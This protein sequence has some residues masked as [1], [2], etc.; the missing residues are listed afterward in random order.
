MVIRLIDSAGASAGD[1]RRVR[2]S[3]P[4]SSGTASRSGGISGLRELAQAGQATAEYAQRRLAGPDVRGM[5][6]SDAL[7]KT[8]AAR[9]QAS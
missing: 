9:N 1:D 8:A 6:A 7:P 4:C 3:P 5:N 2:V